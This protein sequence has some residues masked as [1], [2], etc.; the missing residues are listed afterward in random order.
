MAGPLPELLDT[1][2]LVYLRLGLRTQ[3]LADLDTAIQDAPSASL[4]FHRALALLASDRAA[5]ADSLK[6]ARALQLA[7]ANL[8]PLEQ[9]GYDQLVADLHAN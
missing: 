4:F 5:A 2:A 9:P 6:K 1:R 8:H 7:R 3:A